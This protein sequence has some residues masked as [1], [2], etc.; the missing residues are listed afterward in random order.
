M[1]ILLL[2]LL[3]IGRVP[4]TCAADAPFPDMERS[5]FRYKEF[6]AFLRTRDVI[7]GY[8][9]GNFHPKTGTKTAEIP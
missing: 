6:V 5:W 8:P 4:L 9:D 1:R 7:Q 2:C 3:L